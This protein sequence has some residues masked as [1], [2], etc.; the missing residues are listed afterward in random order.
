MTGF[1]LPKTIPARGRFLLFLLPALLTAGGGMLVFAAFRFVSSIPVRL[2]MCVGAC[3]I[4]LLAAFFWM[5]F[6]H[7]FG[8]R[9]NFFLCE[10]VGRRVIAPDELTYERISDRLTGY[11]GLVLT[12]RPMRME[13][14]FAPL[15]LPFL[16]IGF[17]EKASHEDW[18]DLLGG[19]KRLIDDYCSAWGYLGAS[20]EFT[21]SLQFYHASFRGRSEEAA[22]Y[23]RSRLPDMQQLLSDFVV[24]NITMYD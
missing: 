20:E 5:V 22:A 11:F 4:W 1:D 21:R 13:A 14:A 17:S 2:L 16:F 10:R 15:L 3:L 9:R 23:F 8:T 24:R 7:S 19:D 6:S 12:V 18:C